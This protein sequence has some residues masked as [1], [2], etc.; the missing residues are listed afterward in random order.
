M[1]QYQQLGL[2]KFG[3]LVLILVA[4]WLHTKSHSGKIK[5]KCKV[6]IT[7]MAFILLFFSSL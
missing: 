4:I 7:V 5:S 2:I 1:T 6:F 3:I